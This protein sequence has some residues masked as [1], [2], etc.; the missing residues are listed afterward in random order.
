MIYTLTLNPA[1]D[2]TIYVNEINKE[3]VTRVDKTLRDAAGKGI[4]TSKVLKQL[5]TESVCF[6]FSAGRNGSFIEESLDYLG[7]ENTFVR[8]HGETRENIKIIPT[9][10]DVLEINESGPTILPNDY[11][12]LIDL[13]DQTLK[14][15]DI[16]ILSGSAP[17]GLESMVYYDI[18]TRYRQ[19]GVVTV[20]DSS[21]HLF[22]NGVKA[23]PT[24]IKPNLYELEMYVNK[25]LKTQQEM[26]DV[27]LD[28]H[29]SGIDHVLVSMGKDGSLYVGEAGIYKVSIPALNPKSTVGAGDSF[30]A[31][32][33][34]AFDEALPIVD[35]LKEAS[36]VGC[37][38]VLS[39]RTAFVALDEIDQ[40]K[41]YIEVKEGN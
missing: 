14:Q 22:T 8:V 37:A 19:R 16:L 26:I 4:N 2:R 36:A 23:G 17:Q 5:G 3:D 33:V 7:I 30:V 29:H 38:S 24:I 31:G 28:L 11:Q 9:N 18:I 39:E 32:F 41:P 27:C 10:G 34:K 35:C 21:K 12:E 13:M 6:G 1:I 25:S 40:I 15:H 20:L